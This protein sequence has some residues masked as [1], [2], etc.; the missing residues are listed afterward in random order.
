VLAGTL[1]R[2]IG[3]TSTKAVIWDWN[4][5]LLDD[6]DCS[7]VA[8]NEVLA[9]FGLPRIPTPSAY[10]AVFGFP[11]QDFYRRVGFDTGPSGNFGA[12]AGSYLKRFAELV[13]QA[14]LQA[15]AL[16]TLDAIAGL[17]IHQ[18]IISATVQD[19]LVQQL[20]AHP[21]RERVHAVHGITGDGR[22][23]SK[24]HVVGAWLESSGWNRD[25]VVMIGDT[26][27]DREI[28][29][30][31]ALRFVG[32]SGGHQEPPADPGHPVIDD[33]TGLTALL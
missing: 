27:H 13:P 10:R 15:N 2:V 14:S 11:I 28:A 20:A 31:F 18:V 21:I 19:V 5:T 1:A 29:N 17:G 4:G 8:M 24:T 7:L 3:T 33:L 12:A 32:F 30:L 26:N 9:E 23:A 6:V 25:E 16:T 22:S